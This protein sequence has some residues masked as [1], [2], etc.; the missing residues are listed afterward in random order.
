MTKILYLLGPRL[1]EHRTGDD[2]LS[3]M[4]DVARLLVQQLLIGLAIFTHNKHIFTLY[5]EPS[6]VLSVSIV[7]KYVLLLPTSHIIP[8]T[9]W[10]LCRT[11]C[12][13][14]VT[15][16]TTKQC[17]RPAHTSFLL[18]FLGQACTYCGLESPPTGPLFL[19]EPSIRDVSAIF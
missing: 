15:G 8:V 12:V 18:L 6:V 14:P 10:K 5:S 11:P 17:L 2:S 4:R 3:R 1:F 19:L 7:S 9:G 16:P 13:N